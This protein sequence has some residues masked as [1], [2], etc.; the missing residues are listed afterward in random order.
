MIDESI[1]N[2]ILV[3]LFVMYVVIGIFGWLDFENKIMN[4]YIVLIG[5]MVD[6]EKW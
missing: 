6:E 2:F 5:Y 1:I 4:L 3:V